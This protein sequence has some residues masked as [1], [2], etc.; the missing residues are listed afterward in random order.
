MLHDVVK[1]PNIQVI[2]VDGH[3]KGGELIKLI[4]YYFSKHFNL[5]VLVDS[6]TLITL[7]IRV[8]F[9]TFNY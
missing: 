1:L 6:R 5:T 7:Y 3:V 9:T 4:F 8:D 2:N